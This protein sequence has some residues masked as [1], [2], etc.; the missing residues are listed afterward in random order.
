[1]SVQSYG[2]QKIYVECLLWSASEVLCLVD[3]VD[4]TLTPL[5]LAHYKIL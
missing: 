1:M 5:L 3:S 4:Q 2:Q